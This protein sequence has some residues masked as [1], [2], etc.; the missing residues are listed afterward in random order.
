MEITKNIEIGQYRFELVLRSKS[1][2]AHSLMTDYKDN[3]NNKL[4]EQLFAGLYPATLKEKLEEL[5]DWHK[6]KYKG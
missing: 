1:T 4:D 2:Y 6:D 5:V 3:L